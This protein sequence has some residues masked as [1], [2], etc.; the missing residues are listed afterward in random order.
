MLKEGDIISG[1]TYGKIFKISTWGESHG[2]AIGVVIDGC[3]AGVYICEY[4]IQKELDKR[5]PNS[6]K[7]ATKR[8]EDDK[9]I[10][11][12]GIFDGKTTGTPIS[13][14]VHNK[15]YISKDYN[16]IKDIYRPSH[17]DF[18]YDKKY[19]FRDYRGGGRAS[20]RE[21][22][23]RVCA[24]AIAK[25]ILTDLG[26]NILAYTSSVGHIK[27]KKIDLSHIYENPLKM[28]CKEAVKEA[29]IFLDNLI[30]EKNSI[31]GTAHCEIAGLKAGIGE[32]V[33]EKLDAMLSMAIMSIGA[34]KG[35]EFGLGFL[36]SEK[37]ASQYNDVFYSEN[38]QILKKTNNSGG[39]LGGM[40]DSSKITINI[41]FKPTPSISI[42]QNTINTK[43]ENTNIEIKGRHDPFIVPRAIPIIESMV[44]ITLLDYILINMTKKIDCVKYAYLNF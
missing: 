17:A 27:L 33:F 20:A 15:D 3:P 28:P 14:I 44:A 36:A 8:A 40:S 39:I 34:T 10:I 35:I 16:N 5:K 19:G 31:G 42:P 43:L 41:A 6:S 23:A 1:S 7:Y 32:P 24:G 37:K 29:T 25:K 11:M 9:V 38:E 12:S 18:T 21:T 26:I 30:K 4:D 22:I 13:L 2:K